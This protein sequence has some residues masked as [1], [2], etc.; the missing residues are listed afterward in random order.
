MGKLF[1]QCRKTCYNI[2]ILY[3]KYI[4]LNYADEIKN[5][6]SM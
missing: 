3:K 5:H 2:I 4:L 6:K 1:A